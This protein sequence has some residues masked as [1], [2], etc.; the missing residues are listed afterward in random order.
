MSMGVQVLVKLSGACIG[1]QMSRVT[2]IGVQERL[3]EKIGQFIRVI[4]A[5]SAP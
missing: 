4:P 5:P 1:C 2:L 3:V